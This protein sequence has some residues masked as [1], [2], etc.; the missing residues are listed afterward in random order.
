[1]SKKDDVDISWTIFYLAALLILAAWL[2]WHLF[3]R[4]ILEGLR[5][6]R[7][8]ELWGIGLFTHQQDSCLQWL[9]NAKVDVVDTSPEFAS[10][11]YGC[12]GPEYVASLPD[13]QDISKMSTFTRMVTPTPILKKEFFALT[14]TS[15]NVIEQRA[16]SYL[17]WP[18]VLIFAGIAVYVSKFSSRAK[19][20]TKHTLES[21]IKTQATMW[22][23]IAP[24]VDFNPIHSSARVPGDTIPDKLPLFAEA[25]SP[26]EWLSYH[27][28][29]VANGVIDR[30]AARRALVMQLGPK[31]NGAEG[32]PLYVCALLAAF[33]LKGT[34]KREESDEFL[35]RL[36]ICWNA[37][38]G[39]HV[40]PEIIA[41]VDKLIADP[42]TGGKA[43][44]QAAAHAF[45]TTAILGVMRWA[46]SMGGVLAPGQ[47][48]WLRGTDR[49]LWYAINNLIP[50]A[51][52]PWRIFSLN[53][54]PKSL[55]PCRASTRRSSR[56]TSISLI[57]K[58]ARYPFRRARVMNRKQEADT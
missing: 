47:F 11:T 35:G 34:Q 46:R 57:P 48:V 15:M 27:R 45:R 12:F 5:W 52:A 16:T 38:T 1:M 17:R 40:P 42:K 54:P 23:V 31:W 30:E 53:R 7:L 13:Y 22:P 28:I 19:F 39:F 58:N 21:F 44:E 26:E 14:G 55:C 37:K 8:A 41:E 25:L 3:H 49:D 4:P 20:R 29:P 36:A 9:L 6:L 43:L 56:S 51:W 2:I 18:L 50:K 33:A 10:M 32:Q 24:I